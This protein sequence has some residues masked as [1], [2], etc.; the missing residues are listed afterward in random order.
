MNGCFGLFFAVTI[1]AAGF[2]VPDS[3]TKTVKNKVQSSVCVWSKIY[4]T[5]LVSPP[6]GQFSSH[7]LAL[8][9]FRMRF[10][11]TRDSIYSLYG[12]VLLSLSI[13]FS[14][15]FSSNSEMSLSQVWGRRE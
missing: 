5:L 12:C 15:G 14:L 4:K 3:L 11:L 10:I 2:T 8:A 9:R 13:K 1:G 6:S 7:R